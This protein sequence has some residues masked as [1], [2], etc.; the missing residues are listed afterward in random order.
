MCQT[1]FY[2]LSVYKLIQLNNS[3]YGYYPYF[4]DDETEAQ[5]G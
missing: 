3:S 4:T 2:M 1:L 5:R